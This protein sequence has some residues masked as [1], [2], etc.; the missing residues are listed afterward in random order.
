MADNRSIFEQMSET[1]GSNY[2][3]TLG[4]LSRN[5]KKKDKKLKIKL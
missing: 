4:I 2:G 5:N 1:L 3:Q